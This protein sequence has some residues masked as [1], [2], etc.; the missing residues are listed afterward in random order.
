[1][2]LLNTQ[3]MQLKAILCFC[4]LLSS[5]QLFA[6]ET[7]TAPVCVNESSPCVSA[8]DCTSCVTEINYWVVSSR[9]CIQKSKCSCPCC[10]FDVYRATE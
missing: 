7:P 8:P 10:E 2:N 4:M 5:T 3:S 9:C 6:Q 1:M